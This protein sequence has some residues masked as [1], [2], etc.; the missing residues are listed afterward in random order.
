M[1]LEPV[2]NRISVL[3]VEDDPGDAAIVRK[4]LTKNN[5]YAF[6]FELADR[7]SL[8][9]EKLHEGVFDILLVDLSLPDAR[10][11]HTIAGLVREN[12]R[13]PIVV[14]TGLDDEN[15]ALQ[16]IQ[17]GAEDYLIKGQLNHEL[18][19]RT[20]RYAMERKRT[21]MELLEAEEM[22]STLIEMS[23]EGIVLSR[24]GKIMFANHRFYQT[25]GFSESEVLNENI[26]GLLS[27]GLTETLAGVPEDQKQMTIIGIE[28]AAK[29]SLESHTLEVPFWKT[30]E[31][32][33]W[34]EVNT[35]P[36][37]YKGG[38]A[39]LA[40]VRDVT[41]QKR[42]E[43]ERQRLTAALV[44][45]NIELR[46]LIYV[47]SHDLRTPLVNVQGFGS[48]LRNSIQELSS[49]LRDIDIPLECQDQVFELLESDIPNSVTYIQ[50]GMASMDSMLAGLLRV[51]R[52]ER[53]S[54]NYRELDMNQLLSDVKISYDHGI[55]RIHASVTMDDL[56]LCYG[57]PNQI[58]QVFSCLLDN[59]LRFS[60]RD[61][62]PI[63]RITGQR[64]KD[65]VV[66]CVED[67]G[68]GIP[69]EQQ[70][71]VF[72]IFYRIDPNAGDGQGMGLT[73][74]KKVISMHG[75][76]VWLES[77]PGVG[78]K[79]FISLP[80]SVDNPDQRIARTAIRLRTV[81]S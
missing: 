56:P 17:E 14:L 44:E 10:G 80:L 24:D 29:T 70:S 35:N 78:S 32:L 73:V 45:K 13:V 22:Y 74:V 57:D 40:I 79:F 21:H 8:A 72:Q 64:E 59:A 52:L 54:P 20:I 42:A 9:I 63:I 31:E 61:R 62:D 27:K 67:N 51:S 43:K 65:Q 6:K 11:L 15:M 33:I 81:R 46:E 26:L 7:L 69:Y 77:E 75:G 49:I 47:S 76:S 34:V 53:S 36:I 38:T 19:S 3:L 25:F 58:K 16:A 66:Y 39:E 60:D 1:T 71:K 48:E 12:N 2:D 50:R 68:V 23:I 18:L 55:S 30:P 5:P 37:Q 28:N 41:H 4:M